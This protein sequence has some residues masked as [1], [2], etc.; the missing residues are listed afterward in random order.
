MNGIDLI[1]GALLNPA[2]P[3]DRNWRAASISDLNGDANVEL[4][5]QHTDGTLAAWFLDD[6]NLVSASL[7]NPRQPGKEWRVAG[8]AD[9]N[10]DESID[11]LFQHENGTL[12]VWYM[13]GV[14]LISSALLTPSNPGSLDWRVVSVVDRNQDRQPDLLF[15]NSADGTLAIWYMNDVKLNSVELSTPSSPGGTWKVV[16]PK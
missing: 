8:S 14:D 13:N 9:F 15:Q 3:G 2:N 10:V 16:A 5:F 4:I 7:L 11:L 6:I 12:A 1:G